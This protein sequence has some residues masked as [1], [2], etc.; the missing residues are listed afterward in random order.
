MLI[1]KMINHSIRLQYLQ[2]KLK[3][4]MECDCFES[5]NLLNI[6]NTLLT[7]K[8]NNKNNY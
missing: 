7:Q 8:D 5:Q 4:L 2:K 1:N 6:K 3:K